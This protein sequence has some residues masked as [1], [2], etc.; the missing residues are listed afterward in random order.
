M[1]SEQKCPESL[2]VED[3]GASAPFT[4]FLLVLVT[5]NARDD[6]HLY[7]ADYDEWQTRI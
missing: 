1:E 5:S 7:Q 3:L 4:P 2:Q 6:A